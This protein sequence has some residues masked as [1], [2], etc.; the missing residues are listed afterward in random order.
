MVDR[1]EGVDARGPGGPARGRGHEPQRLT[2]PGEPVLFGPV[3]EVVPLE[4]LRIATVGL[5]RR[6]GDEG[7]PYVGRAGREHIRQLV[8]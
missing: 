5:T 6:Q 7:E 1:V 8:G 2:Q 3:V 4:V